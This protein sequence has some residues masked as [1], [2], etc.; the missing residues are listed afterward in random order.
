MP[1]QNHLQTAIA[2][3]VVVAVDERA[4]AGVRANTGPGLRAGA[5]R[6]VH[7]SVILPFFNEAESLP[8]TLAALATFSLDHPDDAFVF[9]DDGSTDAGP[10]LV[11][12]AAATCPSI[13]LHRLPQNV[14]KGGA[15]RAGVAHLALG[16]GELVCFMDGD[17]AYGPEHLNDLR[18][19]LAEFDVVIGSRTESPDERRNTRKF[20]RLL[21]WGFNLAV[22]TL[23]GLPLKD[24]QAG[25]KG[26]RSEAASAIFPRVRLR[27]FAF[28][29]ELLFVA[30]ALGLTIAEIPAKVARSHRRKASSVNLGTQPLIMLGALLKVRLNGL[31]GRYR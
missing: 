26:F 16:P 8:A 17:L 10:A 21:G 4:G 12:A 9:V 5:A 18:E 13:R 19:K 30:H 20:R 7:L 28:D 11:A 6:S 31:L 2:R 24:T 1:E 3:P 25:L 14:G 22:R 23:L 15:V 27:G 29:V